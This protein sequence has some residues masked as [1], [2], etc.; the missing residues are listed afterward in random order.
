MQTNRQ[1]ACSIFGLTRREFDQLL[2]VGFP[3]RKKSVSRG[4]DW[5]VDTVE[6]FRWLVVQELARHGVGNEAEQSPDVNAERARLLRSQ[7]NI[8]ELEEGRRRGELL[9]AA[10]V[11]EGWQAAIARA[12]SL[13]L[14]LPPSAADQLVMLARRHAADEAAVRAVRELL[15]G[16]VHDALAE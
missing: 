15:A 12:R 6:A 11:V 13:L 14:G 5:S 10:E 7:A 8:S 2:V 3:A 1:Q 16:L 9:P 4:E